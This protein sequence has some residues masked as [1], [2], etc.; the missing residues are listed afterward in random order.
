MAPKKR[1]EAFVAASDKPALSALEQLVA[2]AAAA[3]LTERLR[4][5]GVAKLGQ[6]QKLAAIVKPYIAALR[7]K[8]KGN[9]LYRESRYEEAAAAY[10][11]AIEAAPCPCTEAALASYN[12]RAAC[13]Q[14]MREPERGLADVRHVLAYEPDNAKAL[15][16]RQVFEKATAN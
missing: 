2:E 9:A 7:E 1:R 11:A 5:L 10:T 13:Y 15:A 3:E 16:R 12:N 4:E 8:E 14:Q 6:R